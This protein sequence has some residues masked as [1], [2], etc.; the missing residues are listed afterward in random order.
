MIIANIGKYFVY[1]TK[2][3]TQ[4]EFVRHD[5][6]QTDSGWKRRTFFPQAR[7]QIPN[8]MYMQMVRH[9][10]D[11]SQKL[12]WRQ[13]FVGEEASD[14]P[15]HSSGG[16]AIFLALH[17]QNTLSYAHETCTR[18]LR[19]L[20]APNFDTSSCK[21]LG[22]HRLPRNRHAFYSMQE[23]CTRKNAQESMPGLRISCAS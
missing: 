4:T 10:S 15:R 7:Q 23:T 21:F 16:G 12:W 3:L 18:N 17:L 20:L 9:R 22:Q 11:R 19:D 13:L 1:D 8:Y 14:W 5:R 6:K 2:F